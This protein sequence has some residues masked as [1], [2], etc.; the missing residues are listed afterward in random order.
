MG[1]KVI[2]YFASGLEVEVNDSVQAQTRRCGLVSIRRPRSTQQIQVNRILSSPND[3][4]AYVDAVGEL[5]AH[6]VCWGGKLPLHDI[7]KGPRAFPRWICDSSAIG[8][9]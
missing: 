6:P 4:V 1:F 3:F 5:A 9:H 2:G 7:R 8:S